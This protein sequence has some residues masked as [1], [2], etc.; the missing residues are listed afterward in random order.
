MI[1]SDIVQDKQTWI[2]FTAKVSFYEYAEPFY[3]KHQIPC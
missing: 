2:Q 1:G 3:K